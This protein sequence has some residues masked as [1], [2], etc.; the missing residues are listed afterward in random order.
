[1]QGIGAAVLGKATV[2][3]DTAATIPEPTRE[4]HGG[5]SSVVEVAY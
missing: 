3:G 1:V 5:I 4:G 2:F